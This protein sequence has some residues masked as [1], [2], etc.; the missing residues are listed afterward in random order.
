M[1][2]IYM[3]SL[4]LGLGKST[5]SLSSWKYIDVFFSVGTNTSQ[6][7]FTSLYINTNAT[8]CKK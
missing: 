7:T 8:F 4:G 5:C 2:K 6:M 3:F 1:T